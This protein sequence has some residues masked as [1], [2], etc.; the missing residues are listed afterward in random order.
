MTSGVVCRVMGCANGEEWAREGAALGQ[1]KRTGTLRSH[2]IDGGEEFQ[3]PAATP[4]FLGSPI[5]QSYQRLDR[6]LSTDRLS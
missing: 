6:D 2:V 3:E 5:S 1:D 4:G